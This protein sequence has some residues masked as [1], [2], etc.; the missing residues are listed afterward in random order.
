MNKVHQLINKIIEKFQYKSYLE[1]GCRDDA[2]FKHITA[3]QK[4]GVDPACGGTLRITSDK[5]FSNYNDKFDI[6]F[7]DGLHTYEQVKKD[8]ENSVRC[9]NENGTIIIHD[10]DPP[11]EETQFVTQKKGHGWCGDVWKYYVELRTKKDVDCVCSSYEMM[12]VVRVRD[13]KSVLKLSNICT[14]E[15]F[16]FQS[17]SWNDLQNNRA[18]WLNKMNPGDLLNWID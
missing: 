12:G 5:Y 9:L 14:D 6:I 4:V 7:I 17:L 3:K 1:I 16:N 15:F 10:C 18:E 13:N 8:F 2:T 11:T